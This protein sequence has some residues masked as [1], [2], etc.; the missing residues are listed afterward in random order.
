[1]AAGAPFL[2]EQVVRFHE[3]DRAGI[4]YFARVFE[5]CHAAYE[6][7]LTEALEIDLE[8][9]FVESTWVMPLV[10]SEADYKSPMRLG[11]R[12]RVELRVAR[13][14]RG[15]ITFAYRVL[16]QDDER[17]HAEV[18][19]IH[20]C[21]QRADFQPIPVPTELLEGLKRLGLSEG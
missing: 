18:R 16:N 5:Y 12:L 13:L 6:T 19:L 11:D 21:A 9:F 17:L 10:H 7:M 14:G 8:R 4:V 2:H 1:M 3:I 15:S 20:A